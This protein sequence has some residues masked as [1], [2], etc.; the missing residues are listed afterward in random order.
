MAGGGRL[1]QSM[2]AA[3]RDLDIAPRSQRS[4]KACTEGAAAV[5]DKNQDVSDHAKQK[6]SSHKSRDR[7]LSRRSSLPAGADSA[8]CERHRPCRAG[9]GPR[10]GRLPAGVIEARASRTA[11]FVL[12][13]PGLPAGG[14]LLLRSP[15]VA[16]Q[17]APGGRRRRCRRC[18]R[19]RRRRRRCC[20][21]WR[22]SDSLAYELHPRRLQRCPIASY[23]DRHV[24][25]RR[26]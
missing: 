24:Q 5:Q 11:A 17:P 12:A 1:A 3:T 20:R 13:T 26:W 6:N 22:P 10:E 14:P 4:R 18:R 2:R 7:H 25:P 16:R 15:V 21:R 19:C 8:P 9:G 23:S